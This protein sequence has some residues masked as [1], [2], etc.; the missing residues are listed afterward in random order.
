MAKKTD[1]ELLFERMN[2]VAGMPLNENNSVDPTTKQ[3][4]DQ[5]IQMLH[6]NNDE[7][8]HNLFGQFARQLKGTAP[9]EASRKFKGL[10][11]Y[12]QATIANDSIFSDDTAEHFI[13]M[14]LPNHLLNKI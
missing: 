14:Y 6:Y 3:W 10:T 5:I 7:K 8:V 4:G 9:E 13:S 11:D 1:K 12:I 2:K